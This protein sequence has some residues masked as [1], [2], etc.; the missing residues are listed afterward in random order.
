MRF[1][2]WAQS[3]ERAGDRPVRGMARG[4]WVSR[5]RWLAWLAWLA[6]VVPALTVAGPCYAQGNIDAGRSPAQI[7]ADACAVCHR[8]AREL[9]RSS[10]AFLR[11]HY[12]SGSE[13]AAIMAAY[14]ARLPPPEPRAAQSKRGPAAAAENPAEATKQLPA[15]QQTTGDQAKSAQPKGRRAA[16]TSEARALPQPAADE[17]SSPRL[18]LSEAQTSAPPVQLPSAAVQPQARPAAPALVPFQE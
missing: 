16:S 12:T 13:Q 6:R 1:R 4:F 18:P 8:D 11:Q 3:C 15:Q 9:R 7:F 5:L 10:A 17:N 2:S 14:L